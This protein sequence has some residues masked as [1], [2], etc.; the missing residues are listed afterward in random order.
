MRLLVAGVAGMAVGGLTLLLQGLLPGTW[1][2]LANSGAVWS[3]A[4]FAVTAVL[5]ARGRR[6]AV[7]GILTL[8]GA[9]LGYYGA[10]TLF[11]GDDLSAAAL[12][13]PAIWAVL[14]VPAGTM[15]G[16]A[17]A[18]GRDAQRWHHI[19]GLVVL[20]GVFTAEAVYYATVLRYWPQAALFGT[21]GLALPLLLGR[22]WRD[23]LLAV[24]ALVPVT[25]VAALAGIA[26]ARATQA[27]FLA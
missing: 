8:L 3:A 17:A 12:R 9:V 4:A 25:A 16:L 14:A 27:A 1:N 20:G 13:G 7:A 6:A 23:R 15:F 21:L 19:A 18:A 11:L 26:L 24:A 2:Q 22:T 10:T 5:R